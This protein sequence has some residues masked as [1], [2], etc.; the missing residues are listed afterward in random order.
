MYNENWQEQFEAAWEFREEKLYPAHFGEKKQGIYAL[1][2]ELFTNVFRQP[3]YDPAGLLTGFLSLSPPTK[4]RVGFMF[5]RV[6]PML[7]T[8]IHL[9]LTPRRDLAVN[10]FSNAPRSHVGG[11]SCYKEWWHSRFYLPPEDFR[12]EV[13]WGFG[14]GYRCGV[15]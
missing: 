4:E 12:G 14:T 5:R 2:E 1:G 11:L 9:S 7:G 10:L 15:P 13:P 6:C 3:S 8:P